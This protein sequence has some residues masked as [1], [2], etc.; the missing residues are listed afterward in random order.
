MQKRELD[1]NKPT[2]LEPKLVKVERDPFL[3]VEWGKKQW[4]ERHFI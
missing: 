4:K 3:R 1:T 2:C